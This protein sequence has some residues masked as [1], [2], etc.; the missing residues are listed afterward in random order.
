MTQKEYYAWNQ[1]DKDA[2]KII[3]QLK[4]SRKKFDG[5]WGPPR[6]GLPLAVVISHAFN[7]PLLT[8]CKSK[9]TLVVDDIA[10]TGKTLNKYAGKNFIATL[11][12]HSQSKYVP[13]I[14]IRKKNKKWII[15]PWE[16]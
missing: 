2:G 6:G 11:F 10:D 15:F 9:R 5:V 12:Y 3:R 7:I 8:K 16:R 14:W 1:F 4:K 13:N